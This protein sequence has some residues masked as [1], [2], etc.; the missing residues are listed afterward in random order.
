MKRASSLPGRGDFVGVKYWEVR[1]PRRFSVVWPATVSTW[2]GRTS[3]HCMHCSLPASNRPL[4]ADQAAGGRGKRSQLRN[5]DEGRGD[6]LPLNVMWWE[7]KLVGNLIEL[8]LI[9]RS[10]S[11][12]F[13]SHLRKIILPHQQSYV[14]SSVD[15]S[16]GSMNRW[17]SAKSIINCKEYSVT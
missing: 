16:Y 11:G 14:V 9:T 13:F 1:S 12:R 4:S 2:G 10:I 5:D 8:V 6:F 15:G 7:N 17:L 3:M